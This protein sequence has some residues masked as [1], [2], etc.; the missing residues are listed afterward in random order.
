MHDR[1]HRLLQMIYKLG[2]FGLVD[3]GIGKRKGGDTYS[4][5]DGA[6]LPVMIASS[7]ITCLHIAQV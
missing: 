2:W 4:N 6:K 7:L 1:L 5:R 3:N